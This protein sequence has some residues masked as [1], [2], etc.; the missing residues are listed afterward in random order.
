[1]VSANSGQQFNIQISVKH[2]IN[3]L[4]TWAAAASWTGR[5]SLHSYFAVLTQL[6]RM[7]INKGEILSGETLLLLNSK[8]GTW[9]KTEEII[10]WKE[11][12]YTLK[13]LLHKQLGL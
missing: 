8:T 1:M 13:Q 5:Q 3:D 12:D 6:V 10:P 9:H 2:L 7:C 11:K 4:N